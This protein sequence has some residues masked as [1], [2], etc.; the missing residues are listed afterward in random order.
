MIPF[1][2]TLCL[3]ENRGRLCTTDPLHGRLHNGTPKQSS[4]ND[5]PEPL[6]VMETFDSAPGVIC[7][8]YDF[9][10]EFSN[11]SSP[12]L[13]F[14]CNGDR[15]RQWTVIGKYCFKRD[16]SSLSVIWAHV[17]LFLPLALSRRHARGSLIFIWAKR[18]LGIVGRLSV[19]SNT[20]RSLCRELHLGLIKTSDISVR[21]KTEKEIHREIFPVHCVDYSAELF[22]NR[23][24]NSFC[25]KISE[26][27]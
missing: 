19:T 13:S 12:S 22:D 5:V 24:Q 8:P 11:G 3:I 14:R 9:D 26:L 4:V 6:T 27:S 21:R 10:E 20:C 2:R 15:Q 16:L 1:N 18:M 25:R 17:L 23:P 7:E